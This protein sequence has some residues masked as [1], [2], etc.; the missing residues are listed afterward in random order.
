MKNFRVITKRIVKD[1]KRNEKKLK[2]I[3]TAKD[4]KQNQKK[5]K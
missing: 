3:K 2:T 4:T 1:E 5:G